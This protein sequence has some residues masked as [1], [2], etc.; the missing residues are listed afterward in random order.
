MV[1]FG[2]NK[3][4]A[5]NKISKKQKFAASPV[6]NKILKKKINAEKKVT[7]QKEVLSQMDVANSPLVKNITKKEI[8]L[9][10]RNKAAKATLKP[11]EPVQKPKLKPVKKQKQRQKTQISDTKLL[12]NLMKK[13]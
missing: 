11:T 5:L 13:K 7:F 8:Q 6:T 2:K 1:K 3:F 9:E 4:K 12:F 10:S